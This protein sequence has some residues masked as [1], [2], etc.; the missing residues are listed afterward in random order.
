[1]PGDAGAKAFKFGVKVATVESWIRGDRTPGDGRR[2]AIADDGG[3][4]PHLW[5]EMATAPA[6]PRIPDATDPELD[7]DGEPVPRERATA[8]V[9]EREADSLLADYKI[10]RSQIMSLPDDRPGER[11][12]IMTQLAGI[13]TALGKMTGVG[14]VVSERQILAS[15]NWLRV[16][17][18][19]ATAVE[20]FPEAAEAVADA[21]AELDGRSKR[22]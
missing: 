12:R 16:R 2:R 6:L 20:P 8:A 15:P 22:Q 13:L 9:V 5:D 11:V 14:L 3:P 17:D 4:E 7:D 10:L 19:I 1:M 18:A 21:L